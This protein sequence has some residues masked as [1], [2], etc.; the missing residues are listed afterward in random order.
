MDKVVK[1]SAS[2]QDDDLTL[3]RVNATCFESGSQFD[4]MS[5]A[6]FCGTPDQRCPFCLL[7]VLFTPASL[8]M[9]RCTCGTIRKTIHLP[10]RGKTAARIGATNNKCAVKTTRQKL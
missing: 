5:N 6:W 8:E 7:P 3:H 1:L 9:E 4:W 10:L 2:R